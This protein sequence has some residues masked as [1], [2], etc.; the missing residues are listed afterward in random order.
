MAEVAPPPGVVT[1]SFPVVAPAGT[2]AVICVELLTV[3]AAA[4]PFKVNAVA[5]VKFVPATMIEVPT[6]PLV[7]LN[8]VIVG[9]GIV[10]V[11]FVAEV[12]VPPAVVTE[13]VPVVA[14]LGTLVVICVAL[15]AVTTAVVPFNFT[16]VAAVRFVPVMVTV[17]PTGPL[18]GEKLV[19]VGDEAAVVTVKFVV[20]LA[21]PPVVVTETFPVVAPLGTVAVIWLPLFTANVA[22]IPLNES[23]EAPVR[24]VPVTTTAVPTGPLLG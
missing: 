7:G 4:L 11:K 15:F 9:A 17:V 21:L 14:P 24:F 8:P 23:A 3:N 2:V 20:E 22:V 6:G 16:A 12:A 10:T 5:P 19:I 18:V 13:N 1:E